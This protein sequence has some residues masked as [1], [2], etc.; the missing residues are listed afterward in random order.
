MASAQILPANVPRSTD[1]DGPRVPRIPISPME[2]EVTTPDNSRRGLVDIAFFY[3]AVVCYIATC[4]IGGWMF[5]QLISY[6]S[7]HI[8][9][10]MVVVTA[11]IFPQFTGLF[12]VATWYIVPEEWFYRVLLVTLSKGVC[13]AILA[14]TALRRYWMK[15]PAYNNWK[16]IDGFYFCKAFMF[17]TIFTF[18]GWLQAATMSSWLK[19]QPDTCGV[20]ADGYGASLGLAIFVLPTIYSAAVAGD[21]YTVCP[22]APLTPSLMGWIVAFGFALLWMK[23]CCCLRRTTRVTG[24]DSEV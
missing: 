20:S 10:T 7:F 22:K 13:E 16:D 14:V 9:H 11:L 15:L 5:S 21:L 8:N 6:C 23:C 4:C 12:E 19:L 3:T 18:A 2:I 17:A 24:S 1:P